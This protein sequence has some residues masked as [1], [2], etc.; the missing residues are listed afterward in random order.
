MGND[1]PH[2]PDP[3][4]KPPLARVLETKLEPYGRQPARFLDLLPALLAGLLCLRAAELAAWLAG[5]GSA[6]NAAT[7]T[8]DAAGLDLLCLARYLFLLFLAALPFLKETGRP[9]PWLRLGLLWSALLAVQTVLVEYFF[10]AGLP[11]GS[12]LF[13]YTPNEIL[14]TIKG[15]GALPLTPLA[16]LAA[17]LAALWL[18]LPRLWRRE[19]PFTPPLRALAIVTA[20]ALC[21]VVLPPQPANRGSEKEYLHTLAMN[22]TCYFLDETAAYLKPAWLKNL[23]VKPVSGGVFYDFNYLDRGYPFLHA[24]QT[25]DALGAYFK[26]TSGGRPPNLVFIIVEGLGRS[27]S[28]P[29]AVLGSFTPRLDQTADNA[30]YWNNFLA[31]QGR[32]FGVLSSLLG[33]LPFGPNGFAE[34]G[35]AMPP[36][37]SLLSVLKQ[38][39]YRSKAYCGFNADFDNDRIFYARNGAD[40]LVDEADFGPGYQKSN[41]WGYADREL[42]RR[43]LAAEAKDD[44]EPFVS[45]I[46][47]VTMHTPYTFLGQPEYGQAFERRLDQLRIP[48]A[49]KA[50][51]RA[52][53]AMYES[54]LYLDDEL[55]A[56]LNAYAKL[57][58]YKNTIFIITGDHRLPEIPLLTRI[59]RYH[60]P[61]LL[62]SPLL[63]K[64]AR[65]KS[66]SSQFDVTPS[67]LA[68]LA[69]NYGIATPKAVA[70]LGSGLDM[71][72]AFRNTH[73]IPIKQTKTNL[74]DYVSGSWYM[75]Q[76]T[77]YRLGDNMYSEAVQDSAVLK[78]LR[79]QMAAF[80][81]ANARLKDTGLLPPGAP[82]E[83]APYAEAGRLPPAEIA[84]QAEQEGVYVRAFSSPEKAKAGALHIEATFSNNSDAPSRAFIPLVVLM[85][86]DTKELSETYGKLMQLPP[87]AKAPVALDVKS[88]GVPPGIYYMAIIPSDPDN[89]KSIGTGR[90]KIPVLIN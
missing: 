68:F 33:S 75:N 88:E 39:G 6:V 84:D 42:F 45:V 24:E 28:G 56:F 82:V 79:G 22:K 51:Y 66:V 58:S 29:E 31:P 25:P 73:Y 65:I 63:K 89:G 4:K 40:T 23:A 36:H 74:V 55:D 5:G 57:P 62:V 52:Y 26:K 44:K 3:F 70:W 21:L 90:Y 61:L 50:E 54:T 46:K 37:I 15:G 43:V 67:L 27:F 32:T 87:G 2:Q 10:K 11:L 53:R 12:D 9:R 78:R 34:L 20:G 64:P 49:K 7:I 18:T 48:D 38:Q 72:P 76:D 8:P 14:T 1:E 16:G 13:G 41:S 60:V 80:A 69:A 19:R 59:D 17:A 77:L 86:P 47:T 81:A 85:T 83:L 30:L 35:E 71:E